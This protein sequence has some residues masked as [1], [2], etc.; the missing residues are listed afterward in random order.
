M[1]VPGGR[2]RG[3]ETE[4]DCLRREIRDELPKAQTGAGEALERGQENSLLPLENF[5]FVEIFSLLICIGKSSRNGCGAAGFCYVF[6]RGSLKSAIFPVKFPVSREFGRRRVRS[7]LRRQPARRAPLKALK[8][9][10][11]CG[12]DGQLCDTAA[13]DGCRFH[14]LRSIARIAVAIHPRPSQR[15]YRRR[16]PR[17]GSAQSIQSRR[18]S[19]RE[20]P[21]DLA[22][23]SLQESSSAVGALGNQA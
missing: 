23:L 4:K 5:L 13:R 11:G 1:D 14:R 20:L 15:Q 21:S 18:T 10:P 17:S 9:W 19:T 7:A 8:N 6:G 12:A 22:H 3:R 16:Q 2:R